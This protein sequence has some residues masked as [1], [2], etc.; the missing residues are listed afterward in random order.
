MNIERIFGYHDFYKKVYLKSKIQQVFKDYF[1][2]IFK[3]DFL[4]ELI[5][6]NLCQPELSPTF[7][8]II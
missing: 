7:I 2:C 4:N 3:E 8:G 6:E 5:L 1:Q